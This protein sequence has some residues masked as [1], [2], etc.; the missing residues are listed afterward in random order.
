MTNQ[1]YS[2][3]KNS[4]FYEIHLIKVIYI[5]SVNYLHK[6][7]HDKLYITFKI[8]YVIII[9]YNIINNTLQEY[10]LYYYNTTNNII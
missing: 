9:C 3:E 4:I 5:C 7:N 2:S 10:Y 1:W 6:L 8:I